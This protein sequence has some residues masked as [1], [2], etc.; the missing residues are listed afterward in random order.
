[1]FCNYAN[2]FISEIISLEHF[3]ELTS[4]H[5]LQ[6]AEFYRIKKDK[7]LLL[8][9]YF[10]ADLRLKSKE[11]SE[12]EKERYKAIIESS[13]DSLS[14]YYGV[15][16]DELKKINESYDTPDY[17]VSLGE[18]KRWN[19]MRNMELDLYKVTF[20]NSVIVTEKFIFNI[21]KEFINQSPKLFTKDTILLTWL[22]M[23]T[24]IN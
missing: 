13:R 11:I 9:A 21:F 5:I 8:Q 12:N 14:K 18:I 4:S 1:M 10:I 22:I 16:D 20:I 6:E 24:L 3:I 19:E 2:E 23:T 7:N 15:T 17:L